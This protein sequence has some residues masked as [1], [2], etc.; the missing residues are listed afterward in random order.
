M[1]FGYSTN[2]GPS[3]SA[4]PIAELSFVVVFREAAGLEDKG[5]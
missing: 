1:K 5:V 4:N 2:R 3:L